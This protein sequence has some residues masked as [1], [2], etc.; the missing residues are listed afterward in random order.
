[1]P[2]AKSWDKQSREIESLLRQRP[3]IADPEII[4][5]LDGGAGVQ[6]IIDAIIK[7]VQAAQQQI[8]QAVEIQDAGAK[9]AASEAGINEPPKPPAPQSSPSEILA[10][11]A[12]SSIAVRNSDFH[13]YEAA[14]CQDWLSSDECAPEEE[15]LPETG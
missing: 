4:V 10:S 2:E 13:T 8:L 15:T 1:M 5:L 3:A 7:K 14:S 11:I 6:T 12:K 9:L